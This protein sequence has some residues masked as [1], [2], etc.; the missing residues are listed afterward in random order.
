MANGKSKNVN[1]ELDSDWDFSDDFFND[2]G[3][4]I[5][6]D[7][8]KDDRKVTTKVA[9]G[10]WKGGKEA[11]LTKE[12][13]KQ[14]MKKALPKE[15]SSI[16]HNAGTAL[17]LGKSL[18]ND[19]DKEMR[20]VVQEAK[21]F[22]KKAM[23]SIR[24]FLPEGIAG[25]IDK[26]LEPDGNNSQENV[27][28]EQMMEATINSQMADIFKL[29]AE[30]SDEDRKQQALRNEA[31]DTVNEKRHR[32]MFTI[33]GSM[34]TN[35]AKLAAYQDKVNINWQKKTLELQFRQYYIQQEHL[36]E[37]KKMSAMLQGNIEAV[38]KNTSLPDFVKM[39]DWE[40][41]KKN[42]RE[43]IIN[44]TMESRFVQTLSRNIRK[45]FGNKIRDVKD[46]FL[47]GL[48]GLDMLSDQ[49]EMFKDAGIDTKE[50]AGEMIGENLVQRLAGK[51][52]SKAGGFLQRNVKGWDRASQNIQRGNRNI[53]KIMKDLSD[54]G[55]GER[56]PVVGWLMEILNESVQS[57]F[58]N[59][60]SVQR[61]AFANLD[62]VGRFTNRTNI[63]INDIIPGYLSRM[64]QTLEGIRT[65]KMGDRL[66]YDYKSSTFV[67]EKQA[68]KDIIKNIYNEDERKSLSRDVSKV[69]DTLANSIEDNE[70]I[71]DK[72]KLNN[73]QRAA[74]SKIIWNNRS[75]QFDPYNY[76]DPSYYSG[77]SK[78]DAETYAKFM[79]Q[80]FGEGKDKD[81]L[82]FKLMQKYKNNP[83]IVRKIKMAWASQAENNGINAK[84]LNKVDAMVNNISERGQPDREYIQS[85]IDNG[86]YSWLKEMGIIDKNGYINEKQIG[87]NQFAGYIPD[88][89]TNGPDLGATPNTIKDVS[90]LYPDVG[91]QKYTPFKNR[92]RN[93]IKRAGGGYVPFAN[94]GYADLNKLNNS[95]VHG[96]YDGIYR[97][98]IGKD[99]TAGYTGDGSKWQTKGT[100]HAGEIVWS[101]DD[102]KRMG[103]VLNVEALRK[104]GARAL[105][106]VIKL[107]NDTVN[108][109]KGV[110]N[111]DPQQD[112]NS[113]ES[114]I[115]SINRNVAAIKVQLEK[116]IPVGGFS[117]MVVDEENKA[118]L[119]WYLRSFG[120]V[121]G[122][123]ASL[124][125]KIANG[126]LQRTLGAGR[127]IKNTLKSP[128]KWLGSKA[129]GFMSSAKEKYIDLKDKIADNYDVYVKG[130]LK[131]RLTALMLRNGNYYC[132]DKNGKKIKINS[133]KDITGDVYD[134]EGHLVLAKDL[135]K[136][137]FALN[138]QNGK[139]WV[140]E[141]VVKIK[142]WVGSKVRNLADSLILGG[143]HLYDAAKFVYQSA[144]NQFYRP[145]DVYVKG[146]EEPALTALIMKNEGYKSKSTGK[147][148]HYP[149][150]IDGPV[151][152]PD[153][154]VALS[155]EQI[156]K[157]LLNRFGKPLRI[158]A[159][160][161]IFGKFGDVAGGI[162]GTA[163]S[164]GRGI[165]NGAKNL[166]GG[167]KNFFAQFFGDGGVIFANSNKI[168]DKMDLI[169]KLLDERM[170]GKKVKNDTDGDGL[171]DGS[172]QDLRKRHLA[173]L[174]EKEDAIKKRL[175]EQE[176]KNGPSWFTKL[177]DFFFKGHDDEDEEEDDNDDRDINYYDGGDDDKSKNKKNSE[178]RNKYNRRVGKDKTRWDKFK[179]KQRIK[180]KRLTRKLNKG[181]KAG[182]NRLGTKLANSKYGNKFLNY[183]RKIPK[184]GKFI[185]K[186][187]GPLLAADLLTH[188]DEL[189]A[190]EANKMAQMRLKAG[191]GT[192]ADYKL[193]KL[194]KG[195]VPTVAAA[196]KGG[197]LK[198]AAK[199]T[200]KGAWGLTKGLG[201]GA[202][203]VGKSA[204]N[205]KNASLLGKGWGLAKGIGKLGLGG[206]ALGMAGSVANAAGMPTLG[207]A[208]DTAGTIANYW[209]L[210]SMATSML[211]MGSL[212]S[213]VTGG[214]GAAGSALATGASALATGLT[215]AGAFLLTNPVGWA[216]LGAAALGTAGYFAYKYFT[217]VKYGDLGWLRYVQYGFPDQK[218]TWANDINKVEQWFL[219]GNTEDSNGKITLKDKVNVKEFL[220]LFGVDMSDREQCMKILGWF[221]NRFKPVCEAWLTATAKVNGK[222]N[223]K[224][225]D[226]K[227]TNT[228]KLKLLGMVELPNFSGFDY[229][230][231]PFA[232]LPDL[233]SNGQVVRAKYAAVKAK[234]TEAT[235]KDNGGK[236]PAEAKTPIA[237]GTTTDKKTRANTIHALDNTKAGQPIN[238]IDQNKLKR[239][240]NTNITK[241]G[242]VVGSAFK[243]SAGTVVITSATDDLVKVGSKVSAIDAV[244]YKAYGLNEMDE[245]K[246]Q[247]LEYLERNIK[248]NILL[249]ANKQAIFNGDVDELV[250]QYCGTFSISLDNYG[251]L[252]DFTD[253]LKNR[254]IPVLLTTISATA[255][256][257]SMI[258]PTGMNVSSLNSRAQLSVA[259]AILTTRCNY[260][261][262]WIVGK[263]LWP[264]YKLNI[265]ASSVDVNMNFLKDAAKKAIIN[266]EKQ[267][268]DAQKRDQIKNANF[269]DPSKNDNEARQKSVRYIQEQKDNQKSWL[270]K[271]YDS[272]KDWAKTK[273]DDA[274]A[275]T[276]DKMA[277]A[278]N[279]MHDKLGIGDGITFGAGTGGNIQGVPQSSGNG[280]Q[281]NKATILAAAKIVGVDPGLM[282]A[283]AAQESGFHPHIGAAGSSAK[284]LFQFIDATWRATLNK[285]GPKYGIPAGTPPTNAAANALMGACYIK[286]NYQGLLKTGVTPTAGDLYLAH[287][288]GLGGARTAMRA[289]GNA[290]AASVL[291]KEANSNKS[292][293]YDGGR[294]RTVSEM[295]AFLASLL[296]NK[297]KSFKV[298]VPI[299]GAMTVPGVQVK[300]IK[301]IN[302][303]EAKA[304]GTTP[305][306]PTKVQSPT[307][308]MV[309]VLP[310]G[311]KGF[312]A[313]GSTPPGAGASAPG[314]SYGEYNGDSKMDPGAAPGGGGECVMPSAGSSK[315]A[316]A[317]NT[318]AARAHSSS[319]GYCARYV[320]NALEAAGYKFPRQPYAYM[321][322]HGPLEQAGFTRIPNNTP[323]MAGDI[324]V[325]TP[326]PGSKA[327]HIQIF[328]GSKWYSDFAQNHMLPGRAYANS[329]MTLWRDM[330]GGK[331]GNTKLAGNT[332]GRLGGAGIQ[333]RAAQAAVNS[334]INIPSASPSRPAQHK[335]LISGPTSG[336]STQAIST[337]PGTDR[338]NTEWK[339]KTQ[340]AM[341]KAPSSSS[342][343]NTV[344]DN[345]RILTGNYDNASNQV[346][347][348]FQTKIDAI[349]SA[350]QAAIMLRQLA[351]QKKSNSLLTEIR[352]AIRGGSKG[353][354]SKEQQ[355]GIAEGQIP[356]IDAE[357]PK[358]PMSENARQRLARNTFGKQP[359]GVMSKGSLDVS[360]TAYNN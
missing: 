72:V 110:F 255:K 97:G 92:G 311:G 27:S 171:R 304:T 138:L 328:N 339:A 313:G 29:Q 156:R 111:G 106:N 131:P 124:P 155:M 279:W 136:K 289:P 233:V 65:G 329:T 218:D 212:G 309:S 357:A 66:T 58:G 268:D 307:A 300:D 341:P 355:E 163:L 269:S 185:P 284:G 3:L 95:N 287:F 32:E 132:L 55:V 144:K 347:G 126:A 33:T 257:S 116:G 17:N 318:A 210:G 52:G 73:K 192:A 22:G 30:Q 178:R 146:E 122:D 241:N 249:N 280:W 208:L 201:K 166:F 306:I 360:K 24:R 31:Q 191:T 323:P 273:L 299:G 13:A 271:G 149:G 278:A 308:A 15:Y 164:I 281:A 356:I 265:D 114:Y 109:M 165:K 199:A 351:E 258:N 219:K 8:V 5:D 247:A 251:A 202:L 204:L 99:Y 290:V 85:V 229:M 94:G 264:G 301:E 184:I 62:D 238:G 40:A 134:N 277:N 197:L 275:W 143:G 63:T 276:Q 96:S 83:A 142:N 330:K 266:D 176:S 16:A 205:F 53:A 129:G 60:N 285:Y 19:L 152:G 248:E 141:K 137:S 48:S 198:R 243:T 246:I 352:D 335:A 49:A 119:P 358:R 206:L 186:G 168:I 98:K 167:V 196:G 337:V 292:I 350:G 78:E 150:D 37:F 200:G 252:F 190:G 325:F 286:E 93:G 230:V 345:L 102:I 353:K 113:E 225:I 57:S 169:Y 18:Y 312:M 79:K 68:K 69:V 189:N 147:T 209:T 159:L 172:V 250:K 67:T 203:N 263:G 47:N 261:S 90:Q 61:L 310:S 127:W 42:A 121:I 207:S 322:A 103:G 223:I 270:E 194:P 175:E 220:E 4:D 38:V 267:V 46:S 344:I 295:R 282:A 262:I 120:E 170:P 182:K 157:G 193:Q 71:A 84:L 331:G 87:D 293:F 177:K 236:L 44:S 162:F 76:Q 227:M 160:S 354:L 153:G 2:N 9:A 41:V 187:A 326:R 148:I 359:T 89:Y 20:P 216:I 82:K 123:I 75:E 135:I 173:T 291:P 130:E 334:N 259:N 231:S 179:Q 332:S 303:K 11:V 317:A 35:I 117:Q 188:S 343:G 228:E 115:E 174:K 232:K 319:T 348:D 314:G 125:F 240:S 70:D 25:K 14:F 56:L 34:A 315:A 298:D 242:K 51:L 91:K 183:G 195:T 237:P 214:L 158:G 101:Q 288:L 256:N 244:R 36:D 1:N 294:P 324:A 272:I 28:R 222:V 342:G 45:K 217:K 211:G 105:K 12:T 139:S 104:Y 346:Q 297:A 59:D 10:I 50:F 74:L 140:M 39:K 112:N 151:I 336:V 54:R 64:Y 180:R 221:N 253:Y 21:Q 26:I 213:I 43:R 107:K 77:V 254:F 321:Y 333:N 108:K 296:V 349:K 100:V 320:A 283:M 224:D 302:P 7:T 327:G 340:G 86:G 154:N 338:R 274:T 234:I 128:F 305:S 23:P 88:E 181:F 133:W 316:V 145:E 161:K 118:R 239:N 226:E 235:K 215:S 6:P 80:A 260:G 81:E 245:D